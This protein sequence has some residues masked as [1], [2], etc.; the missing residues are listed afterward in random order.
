MRHTHQVATMFC[1]EK[2]SIFE[3]TTNQKTYPEE[4][5]YV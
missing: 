1:L 2:V 3:V 4:A 5:I